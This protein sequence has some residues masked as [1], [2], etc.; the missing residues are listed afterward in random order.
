MKNKFNKMQEATL[1][2]TWGNVVLRVSSS[3]V[4]SCDLPA[5]ARPPE[6][7]LQV[8]QVQLANKPTALLRRAVRAARDMLAGNAVADLPPLDPLVLEQV[9]EFR[10]AI[11]RAMAAIPRGKTVTYGDL[12]R[13]AGRA[14]AARAA[15]S[16]CGANPVALFLP[17]HRVLGAKGQLGGFSSGVAWKI[18][19]LKVEGARP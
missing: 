9:P 16:A 8:L 10:R 11:W 14:G 15:G 2:T 18:H 3:G 19:L 13:Q 4:V 7:L 6:K 12:A 5:M 17:C 1:E